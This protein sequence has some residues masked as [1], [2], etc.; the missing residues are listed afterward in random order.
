MRGRVGARTPRRW[1]VL[2]CQHVL[3]LAPSTGT[4]HRTSLA[5]RSLVRLSRPACRRAWCAVG[6]SAIATAV[7]GR[8]HRLA[9]TVVAGDGLAHRDPEPLV[10][11]DR[12]RVFLD[13]VMARSSRH[14]RARM[15]S[16]NARHSDRARP[17]CRTSGWTATGGSRSRASHPA[18][19]V[20]SRRRARSVVP[21]RRST[22]G[23]SWHSS[24]R[25]ATSRSSSAGRRTSRTASCSCCR[26]GRHCISRRYRGAGS[27][28][29]KRA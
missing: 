5:G 21:R 4:A 7:G 3:Q 25:S 14:P 23:P 9:G 17:P 2:A 24:P 18:P 12:G 16:M 19:R 8:S 29:G 28:A 13:D 20:R 1:V 26:S 15:R 10:E 11:A 27:H 22:R 6:G